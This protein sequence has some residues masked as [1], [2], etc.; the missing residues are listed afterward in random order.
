MVTISSFVGF[1]VDIYLL[2]VNNRNTR[3][4]CEIYSKLTT[5]TPERRQRRSDVFV[6]VNFEHNSHTVLVFLLLTLSMTLKSSVYLFYFRVLIFRDGQFFLTE[7]AFHRCSWE[8]VFWK[9]A[10]IL[11]ENT[12]AEERFQ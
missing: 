8:N 2:N 10:V 7:L 1:Q 6:V 9:Y 12:H 11:Q 4:R 3:T 5:K